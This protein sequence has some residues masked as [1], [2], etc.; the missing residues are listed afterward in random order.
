MEPKKLRR[1]GQF[2]TRVTAS[3]GIRSWGRCN[4]GS[5]QMYVYWGSRGTKAYST[6]ASTLDSLT[7][8]PLL[9]LDPCAALLRPQARRRFKS[10]I[11]FCGPLPHLWRLSL[12]P[13]RFIQPHEHHNKLIHPRPVDAFCCHAFFFAALRFAAGEP[14]TPKG[15]T[16]VGEPDSGLRASSTASR[17]CTLRALAFSCCSRSVSLS[18]DFFCRTCGADVAGQGMAVS[19]G[20][21]AALSTQLD[22]RPLM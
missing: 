7:V 14:V 8:T 11:K 19:E 9:S 17:A 10:Q 21:V 18:L 13:S 2:R 5:Q 4:P 20:S 12:T 1:N 15:P 16:A 6:E 3:V 22:Q